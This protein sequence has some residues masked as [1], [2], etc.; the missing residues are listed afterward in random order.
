MW[1]SNVEYSCPKTVI[2]GGVIC[3]KSSNNI[4]V[5]VPNDEKS[6]DNGEPWYNTYCWDETDNI[7]KLTIN[8]DI[9]KNIVNINIEYRLLYGIIG[10]NGGIL[11]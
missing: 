4:D 1:K 7:W 5:R 6:D 11:I 3:C 8:I 9:Y 2:L 10:S